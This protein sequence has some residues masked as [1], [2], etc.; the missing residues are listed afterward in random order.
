MSDSANM[1]LS[2]AASCKINPIVC[3]AYYSRRFMREREIRKAEKAISQRGGYIEDL[4]SLVG[5]ER[6]RA[7]IDEIYSGVYQ[8]RAGKITRRAYF[9]YQI[10]PAS[11]CPQF[12]AVVSSCASPKRRDADAAKSGA[13]HAKALQST[14]VRF[15]PLGS[16]RKRREPH[17]NRQRGNNWSLLK[18]FLAL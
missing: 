16:P 5:Q 2:L 13:A 8:T 7:W 9:L 14:R 17:E 6:S 1:S 18:C 3:P 11:I 12:H 4:L 15:T 10:T